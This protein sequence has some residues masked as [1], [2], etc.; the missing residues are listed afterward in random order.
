MIF[1]LNCILGFGVHVQNLQDSCI[2]THMAVCF[3]AFLPFTHIWH[4]SPGYPSPAP[5]LSH[6]YFHVWCSPP[7]VHVFSLFNTC[8]WVRKR[9][10]WF[11]I[12]VSVCWEWRFPGS[13]ISLQRTRT[14]HFWWLH[15]IPWCILTFKYTLCHIFPVQSIIDGHLGWFQ[16]FATVNSAA[17]NI[18]VHM[19]L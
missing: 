15:N 19:S 5:L 8:L 17:M 14:H 2:G 7:R 13:S 4:F 16:V 18:H 12:L 6:P 9:G 11:S 3:A 1:F 10:V